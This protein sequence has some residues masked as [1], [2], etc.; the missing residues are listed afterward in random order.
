[1][2]GQVGQG[3]VIAEQE[4]QAAVVVLEIQTFPHTGGHL[5]DEAENAFV[6]AGML[7]V[8]QIG[9]KIQADILL[10]CL[11]EPHPPRAL[12]RFQHKL[13]PGI[14]QIKP[15]VQHIFHGMAVYADQPISRLDFFSGR[16]AAAVTPVMTTAMPHLLHRM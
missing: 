8:H 12:L 3:D 7:L 11:T 14:H 6:P 15:I 16:R 13:Q 5:V 10:I 2:L 4:G 9:L 1:M